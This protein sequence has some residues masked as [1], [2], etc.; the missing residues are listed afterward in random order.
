MLRSR[1]LRAAFVTASLLTSA[2]VGAVPARAAEPS[3]RPLD[4]RPLHGRGLAN[5]TAF[6]RL[7]GVVRWFHPSDE[8]AA[9]DWDRLAREG[10][11]RVEGA[12][13]A[14]DLAARLQEVIRPVAPSVRVVPSAAPAP[15]AD[16][17]PAEGPVIVWR[18]H[19]LGGDHPRSI[20]ASER[21]VLPAAEPAVGRLRQNTDAAPLAGGRARLRALGRFLPADG[22][23][24]GRAELRWSAVPPGEPTEPGMPPSFGEPVALGAASVA[25]ATWRPLEIVAELPE[26]AAYVVVELVVEGDGRAGLDEVGIERLGDGPAEPLRLLANPGFEDGPAG[27]PP[28]GWEV[29]GSSLA[30]VYTAE[31]SDREPA[32]GRTSAVLERR[33]DLEAPRPLDEPWTVEL[34]SGLVARVPLSLRL[35]AEGRTLPRPGAGPAAA[36]GDGEPVELS[37]DDRA[38]RLSI[39]TT[40]WNVL[41]HFYPYFDLTD[42]GGTR[43]PAALE[44]TLRRA[45]VDEGADAFRETLARLLAELDDGHGGVFT[46]GEQ[47]R[48]PL[49]WD[50][51]GDELV[52]TWA[53]PASA[54][55]EG[56]PPLAA[57][58]AVVSIDGVPA[59]AAMRRAGETRSAATPQW[60]RVRVLRDLALGPPGEEVR[61]EVERGDAVREVAVA[62]G[63]GESRRDV[64]HEP[65]PDPVAEVAPGVLYVDLSRATTAAFEEALPRLAAADGVVFDLRGYPGELFG[66]WIAHLVDEPVSS[67]RWRVPRVHRPDRVGLLY[68]EGNWTIEPAA[69]RLGGRIAVLTDGRAVSAAETLLGIVEHYRLA[70]IFGGPTAGTNGN[71]NPTALPG[72]YH[73]VWTGMRVDKH[74]G[75]PHHGVGI[76]PTVPVGRTRAGVAAG[77]DEVLEAAVAWAAEGGAEG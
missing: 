71:V 51:I 14:A 38:S 4:D 1:A 63:S 8:A 50:Q 75:S 69:P 67:A 58:D 27:W 74:D 54:A 30:H 7:L 47:G 29:E 35:D 70:E 2:A 57:G 20:Y 66:R 34:G 37:G 41:Q 6:A 22:G 15:P 76:L 23:G 12:R 31:Q 40:A 39:A 32:A 33:P 16:D 13:D 18:H 43:W 24:G 49:A 61:L 64:F 45:A 68:D 21:V 5:L 44:S 3:A 10:V 25:S 17:P 55:E 48:L 53:D 28:I 52:V 77:R 73:V 65:R 59:A 46:P 26:E 36:P 19:G 62:Y 42:P 11:V 9:A 72:T 60:R 56:E